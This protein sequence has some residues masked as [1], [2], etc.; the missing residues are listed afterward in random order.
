MVAVGCQFGL[1]IRAARV[2]S[3][4]TVPSLVRLAAGHLVL[5]Q[6]RRV[7]LPYEVRTTGRGPGSKTSLQEDSAEFDTLSLHVAD[8]EHVD[9]RSLAM[10]EE[11]GSRPVIRSTLA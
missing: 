10:A 6:E 9:V 1:S 5:S 3:S 8:E 11:A 7:R 4:S 2:R